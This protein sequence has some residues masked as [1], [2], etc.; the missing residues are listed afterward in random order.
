MCKEVSRDQDMGGGGADS[1]HGACIW[2]GSAIFAPEKKEEGERR[3]GR[4]RRRWRE[5]RPH[6]K[7]TPRNFLGVG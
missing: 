4:M 6:R 2:A 5:G 3:E 7:K 1:Q